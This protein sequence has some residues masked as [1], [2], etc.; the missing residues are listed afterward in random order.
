MWNSVVF[1]GRMSPEATL[2]LR[3]GWHA[4][5]SESRGRL[6]GAETCSG[7]TNA[8]SSTGA[9]YWK[10]DVSGAVVH[11]TWQFMP[12]DATVTLLIWSNID[13]VEGHMLHLTNRDP[14]RTFVSIFMHENNLYVGEAAVSPGYPEPGLFQQSL[15]WID[16]N[17]NGIRC[18]SLYRNGFPVPSRAR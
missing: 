13:L 9:G 3:G 15:A 18:Q 11:A 6:C 2:C 7:G 8:G 12:R 5:L 17:G 14:S 4:V 1:D 16:E 10:A